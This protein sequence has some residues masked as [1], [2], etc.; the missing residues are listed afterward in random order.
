MTA[1]S[2][3][4]WLAEASSPILGEQD[5]IDAYI[6]MHPKTIFF[7]NLPAESIVLDIGAADAGLVAMKNWLHYPRTDIKII[8]ASISLDSQPQPYDLHLAVDSQNPGE[9]Q[10]TLEALSPKPSAVVACRFFE[11]V[12][13]PEM[14]L[15]VLAELLPK[16][17]RFYVEW[18]SPHSRL[19]PKLSE[20]QARGFPI[21]T[22]NF[23]DDATHRTGFSVDWMSKHGQKHGLRCE[24]RGELAM[25][26][27][28]EQLR[29]HGVNTKN[30]F[31]LS[32][33]LWLHTRFFSF[34]IFEKIL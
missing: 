30:T 20:I 12:D 3:L 6:A 32:T 21:S 25:P 7:K 4:Q 26:F 1:E 31:L 16:G 14:M 29:N 10:T 34:A 15:K 24:Q 17:G 27:L 23:H 33:A 5:L 28:A 13:A 9:L 8:G 18:P 19:L 22:L 2:L 11:R